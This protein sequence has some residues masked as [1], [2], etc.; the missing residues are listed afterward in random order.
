[1][2][3]IKEISILFDVYG[4]LLTPKKQAYMKMYFFDDFS[5]NEIAS[6][7]KIT[8]PAVHE[9][10]KDAIKELNFYEKKLNFVKKQNKR[11]LLYNK[12]LDL[13]VKEQFL[14]IEEND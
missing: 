4:S 5:L 13:D 6:T 7:K 1:M 9:A 10:I 2:K 11:L 3:K 8:K 12:L 14:E